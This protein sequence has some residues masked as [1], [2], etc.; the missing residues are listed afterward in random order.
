MDEGKFKTQPLRHQLDC[1]MKHGRSE[2]YALNSEQ[3]TG[4]TWVIINESADLWST[5]DCDGLLVFAPN[6]VHENWTLREL[7]K[8]MPDWVR[9]KAVAWTPLKTKKALAQIE[10]LYHPALAGQLRIFT[11]NHEALQNKRG[12]EA[13]MRFAQSCTRLMIAVDE[14]DGFKNPSTIGTKSLMK[15]K[16]LSKYRRIMSGTPINNAPFDA[17]AQYRFLDENILQTDSY[18]A[19]KAEYAELMDG[20]SHLIQN[21]VKKRVKLAPSERAAMNDE[22]RAIKTLVVQNGRSELLEAFQPVENALSSDDF[23]SV[24]SALER[25]EGMFSPAPSARKTQVLKHMRAL[26]TRV[27]AHLKRLDSAFHPRRLPQIVERD[28]KKGRKKFRNLDKLARLI[29]P[30]TFRV[31]KSECLDLPE[32]IYK[33]LLFDLTPQQ[34]E[35]YKKARDECRI[36]LDG[37]E[38]PLSKLAAFSKLAQITSGYYTHPDSEEP[39]RIPGPNPKLDILVE[40][41]N[42]IIASGEQLIVWARYRIEIEDIVSRLQAEG[43]K[44]V[45]YH[46]GVG[47]QQRVEN[48]DIFERGEADVFV[49]NARAGGTGITLIGAAY[50]IYFSNDFSYRSRAQSED[51][52]HRIGQ[53][54]NVVYMNIAAKDT[55]DIAVIDALEAKEEIADKIVN[56]GRELLGD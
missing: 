6:G 22:L 46:G 30:H 8:H 45:E 55:I 35:A 32:K 38:L 33:T 17:F 27:A 20:R 24:L 18:Y 11:M 5:G 21:I 29:A 50:T 25:M 15:L 4:K 42:S 56:Q 28:K 51:R 7:P 9:W 14:S 40:R 19:F 12:M 48:I 3:G 36:V 44:I 41:A 43:H 39:V 23:A 53:T 52:N 31:L 13:A 1:L 54:R 2:Y 10:S 47:K 34:R 26:S 49:G 37:K 16:P